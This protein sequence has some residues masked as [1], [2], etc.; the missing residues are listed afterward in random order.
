[1]AKRL[2]TEGVSRWCGEKPVEGFIAPTGY[3]K[4]VSEFRR[5]P[6]LPASLGGKPPGGLDP[7]AGILPV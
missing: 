2:Q 1:M 7:A 4:Q 3:V 6:G 5:R